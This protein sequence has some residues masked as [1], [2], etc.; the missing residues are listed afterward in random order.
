MNLKRFLRGHLEL[1]AEA[2]RK[3]AEDRFAAAG[4]ALEEAL[5]LARDMKAPLAEGATCTGL[6]VLARARGDLA[7]ARGFLLRALALL[8]GSGARKELAEALFELSRVEEDAKDLEGALARRL[9]SDLAPRTF[10]WRRNPARL[11]NARRALA[12]AIERRLSA[13]R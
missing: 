6:G 7:G 2:R 5:Q 10:S 3:L 13:R 1:L 8:E 9:A 12:R 11:L 4:K